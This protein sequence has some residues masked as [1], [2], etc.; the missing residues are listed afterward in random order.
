MVASGLGCS[1][2]ATAID[3]LRQLTVEQLLAYP[4]IM[5]LF[6]AYAF[7][8]PTL[9]QV[10]AQALRAGEFHRVPVLSGSTRDEHRTFVGLFFDLA[11]QPVTAGQ[12]KLLLLGAFGKEAAQ[13]EAQYPL[14][15]FAT[16]SLAWA[17]V[18]TDRMWAR[19]TFELNQLFAQQMPTYAYEFA[20]PNAP[21]YLPFPESFPPGAFHAA[22]VPYLFNDESFKTHAT[23]EQQ[24]LSDQMIHYWTNFARTG[25]P[26][27]ADLPSWLPFVS[28]EVVPYVQSLA[29]NRIQAVDFAAEHRLD[30]WLSLP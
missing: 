10:P 14:A 25:D 20:D 18:L 12:Y 3:C 28:G 17:A 27:G 23:P 13:V 29:P 6:Q 7:G 2:P 21:M 16:P 9:P 24:Q 5:N 30:F 19:Y 22:D 8:T 11:G 26:N 1:D 15:A 4:Q